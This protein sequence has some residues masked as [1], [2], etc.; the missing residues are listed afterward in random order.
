VFAVRNYLLRP[1]LPHNTRVRR[2]YVM[3]CTV[4]LL[5]SPLMYIEEGF[6]VHDQNRSPEPL[7]DVIFRFKPVEL[8]PRTCV[9]FPFKFLMTILCV[10][11]PLPV[12]LFDP[13]FLLGGVFG[14]IVGNACTLL[15]PVLFLN[16]S[17]RFGCVLF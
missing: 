15:A 5:V 12:G 9:Y 13:V 4:A 14:R 8:S 3:V 11:L 2:Q 1:S 6:G 7:L 16:Y 10:A 17:A